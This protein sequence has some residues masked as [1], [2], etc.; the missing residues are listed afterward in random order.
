MEEQDGTGTKE[1]GG[2]GGLHF[3]GLISLISTNEAN[4]ENSGRCK[5]KQAAPFKPNTIDSYLIRSELSYQQLGG[6]ETQSIGIFKLIQACSVQNKNIFVLF[7][8]KTM[9]VSCKHVCVAAIFVLNFIRGSVFKTV[10]K[11]QIINS[12]ARG[13]F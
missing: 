6:L 11:G 13:L 10:N 4:T 1:M 9:V 8:Y 3:T 5:V 7:S 2:G 12:T